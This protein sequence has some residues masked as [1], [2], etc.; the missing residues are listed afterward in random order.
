[1]QIEHWLLILIVAAP[2]F[3]VMTNRL[4]MDLAAL[5][6]AVLVGV[7]QLAGLGMLGPAH[8]PQNA[9]KAIAGFGQSV[10][11]TLIALFIIT[12]G[13]D[14][15]GIT[16]WIA[17]HVV[18]ISGQNTGKLIALI[19]TITAVLS[20]FMNNLA[21]G[22]LVLPGAMEAARRTG[23]KPGKLLIPVAF[24]SLLGGSATYFTTANIIMSDLLLAAN[25]P[26]KPLHFLDFA[27]AGGLLAI[28]GILFLWA[29]GERILPDRAS[30]QTQ[31][32]V[33]P[34]GSELETI[35]QIGERLWDTRIRP[36]S[37]LIGCALDASEIGRQ[38]GLTITAVQ[39]GKEIFIQPGETRTLAP[40]DHLWIIGREDK[41][42]QLTEIGLGISA[43]KPEGNLSKYGVHFA[44][45]ILSPRSGFQGLTLKQIDFR[46]QFNL[47]IV[48]LKRGTRSYRTDV[49]DIPLVFGDMLLVA[50]QRSYIQA[51]HKDP[52]LITFEASLSDQPVDARHAWQTILIAATAITAAIAG[53]PVVVSMLAGAV[54]TLLFGIISME[55]AYQSIEWSAIFLIAGMYAVSQAM[56]QSGMADF[57]SAQIL[58][59]I[60][61]FGA[62]GLAAGAYLLS[63]FLTQ[64][65]G[66]QITAFVIG[67]IT[68]SAAL[69]M[70][71]N[72]QAIAVTTAIG[73]SAAFL[74]P[75]AHP[76]NVMVLAPG[77]YQFSDFFR[78]GWLISLI[79]FVVVILAMYAF[80]GL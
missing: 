73:C 10:I 36:G 12:R 27:G 76:V 51:L 24:G 21:A 29:F 55:E 58:T 40:G 14:K 5:L 31:Q 74:T 52:N 64:F 35:Y 67:P 18:R 56:V 41:I 8:T 11:I 46:K 37:K 20:L 7:L 33:S 61:R 59:V 45:A 13:M 17:R 28:T 71:V 25:P 77:G 48:A 42:M 78:A 75:L 53:V 54:L 2:L 65:L 15:S 62:L 9:V 79:S 50:G 47:S 80:W 44:E 30:N 66:S 6:M 4:R 34:T 49:G 68:I 39:H 26:Q 70:G 3:F 1:M 60:S 38:Y 19:T 57:L 63:M 32:V 72:P 69:A 43:A 22:A 16:R 23:I